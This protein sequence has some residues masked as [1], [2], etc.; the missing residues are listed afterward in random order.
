MMRWRA[1]LLVMLLASPVGAEEFQ[2]VFNNY[3]TVGEDE[4]VY[5]TKGEKVYLGSVVDKEEGT[6]WAMGKN[7]SSVFGTRNGDQLILLQSPAGD[8]D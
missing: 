4:S 8:N 1:A 5:V 3:V 2:W 7:G 6:F